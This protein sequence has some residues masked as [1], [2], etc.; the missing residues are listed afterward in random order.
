MLRGRKGL[1]RNRWPRLARLPR[2]SA[3]PRPRLLLLGADDGGAEQRDRNPSKELASLCDACLG[4]AG[5]RSR[6]DSASSSTV[7]NASGQ[8]GI[9]SELCVCDRPCSTPRMLPTYVPH[10]PADNAPRR[11]WLQ[12]HRHVASNRTACA[13]A[14]TAHLA[15]VGSGVARTSDS[16]VVTNSERRPRHDIFGSTESKKLKNGTTWPPLHCEGRRSLE[17]V[18]P[19]P[20]GAVARGSR[21]SDLPGD[22]ELRPRRIRWHQFS[23]RSDL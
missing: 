15:G 19:Q 2:S 20:E 22:Q 10:H 17:Y 5:P 21:E 6:P 8:R 13:R 23:R 9:R 11:S 12:R 1:P 4:V 7:P 18:H 14:C 16:C 3:L